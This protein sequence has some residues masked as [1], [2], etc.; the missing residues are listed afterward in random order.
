MAALPG[1]YVESIVDLRELGVGHLDPLLEEENEAWRRELDW[2]FR[3]SA[4]LVRR[5]VQSRSL[6]GFALVDSVGVAGYSYYVVEEGK[7]LIGDFFVRSA[8]RNAGSE[9]RLL[10]A[11]LDAMWRIPGLRRIEAQLM[12]LGLELESKAGS[13]AP[14]RGWLHSYP[15]RFLEIP[16]ATVRRFRGREPMRVAFAPWTESWR[17]EAATLIANTYKGHIDSQINDQYQSHAGAH[18]FLTNIV[19]FL[20]C[21]A[22]FAPASFVAWDRERRA[23]CGVSLTSLV[24]NE[25]GHIT[26]VCV[27]PTHQ[28]QGVGYELLRRSLT[29]LAA[30]GCRNVSLT[31]TTANASAVG[32]YERMGFIMRREF[33]A[34]VW[35]M[36]V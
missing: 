5:F 31:V 18:R 16:L 4:D 2:D 8:V 24:A 30:Q 10:E 20:G 23:M 6:N 12:M 19:Q 32:L 21:G 7:G 35:D 13:A 36:R 1:R 27:A 34:H 15:R 3:P 14:Y 9:H 25:T 22:F 17:D 28:G 33:A 26:Q 11:I 29:A